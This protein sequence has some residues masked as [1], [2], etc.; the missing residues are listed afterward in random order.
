MELFLMLLPTI[1]F[2]LVLGGILLAIVTIFRRQN[3]KRC[4]YCGELV[5]KV[6]KVCKYCGKDI[7]EKV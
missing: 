1:V 4:Y 3:Q 5:Q 7:G 6:A 2:S